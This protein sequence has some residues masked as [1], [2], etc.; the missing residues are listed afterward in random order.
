MDRFDAVSKDG[1]TVKKKI[2]ERKDIMS[3]EMMVHFA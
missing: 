2:P 1:N 3:D